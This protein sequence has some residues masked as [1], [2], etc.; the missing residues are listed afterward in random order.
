MALAETTLS[1]A[2]GVTDKFIVVASATSV[3]VGR[4]VQVE[5]EM[6]Q[7]T[8]DYVAAS[9]TVP[10]IRGQLGTNQAAHLAAVRVVHGEAADWGNAAGTPSAFAAGGRVLKRQDYVTTATMTLPAPGED[11]FVVCHGSAFTLTV[12]VPTKD[13]DGC[14]VTFT[15]AAGAAY[16]FEF[17]GGLGGASTNYE[18]ITFNA[19]GAPAFK[20]V[21]YNETWRMLLGV[22]VTGTVTNVTGSLG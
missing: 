12:P 21:A 13:L 11:L 18:T 3:G 9:T 17:T 19:T 1:S 20:V 4:I 16:V 5:G 15:G 8:K 22:A 7:V 6:M 14:E 2:V 10:V